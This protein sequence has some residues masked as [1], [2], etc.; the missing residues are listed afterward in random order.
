M[1]VIRHP[2]TEFGRKLHV[3]LERQGVS[4]RELARRMQ[5]GNPE[6]MRRNIARWL[7]SEVTAVVP[8][9]ASVNATAEAL[10]VSP[11]ALADEEDE[12]DQ[13][14]YAPLTRAVRE[15]VR[16]ELRK[17]KDEVVA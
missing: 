17:A 1:T 13:D 4:V 9:P 14:V 6:G 16:A 8:S 10:G 15:V 11:D 3:E 7:S 5:P 2:R 12:D